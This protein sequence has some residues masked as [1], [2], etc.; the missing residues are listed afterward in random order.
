MIIIIIESIASNESISIN[1][2]DMEFEPSSY[3]FA[4]G[5]SCE[6]RHDCGFIRHILV[7]KKWYTYVPYVRFAKATNKKQVCLYYLIDN[8][9]D[10][11][12]SE[13]SFVLKPTTCEAPTHVLFFKCGEIHFFPEIDL[14]L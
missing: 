3:F 7:Y 8:L 12:I 5:A 10:I 1:F 2:T 9:I 4:L 14:S 11:L 13:L 6:F